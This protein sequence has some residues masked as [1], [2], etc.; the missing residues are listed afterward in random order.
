M[1][2]GGASKNKGETV[3]CASKVVVD[4]MKDLKTRQ[5]GESEQQEKIESLQ[6]QEG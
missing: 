1:L 6:E 5:E 4:R 3:N 2:Q